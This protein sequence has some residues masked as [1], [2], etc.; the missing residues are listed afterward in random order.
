MENLKWEVDQKEREI[1]SLKQQLE[2]TEQQSRKELGGVQQL[3][4]VSGGGGAWREVTPTTPQ[5]RLRASLGCQVSG[6]LPPHCWATSP[7]FRRTR[8]VGGERSPVRAWAELGPVNATVRVKG[9]P[10]VTPSYLSTGSGT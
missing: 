9:H 10:F 8:P 5:Q 2:L 1:Q 6:A 3:L 7:H 4:Q